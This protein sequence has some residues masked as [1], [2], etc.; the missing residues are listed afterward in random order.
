MSRF[1]TILTLAQAAWQECALLGHREIDVEHV[2]LAAMDDRDIA[3]LLGRHGVTREGTRQQVDAVVRDQLTSLGVDLGQ[4]ALGER[5]PLTELHHEAVGVGHPGEQDRIGLPHQFEGTR[6][7]LCDGIQIRIA[8]GSPTRA[9]RMCPSA[10]RTS[11]GVFRCPTIR[12][13]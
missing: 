7:P 12:S 13:T 5:R 1:G 11:L 8:R 10:E 6:Y 4:T 3:E 9:C 2:L